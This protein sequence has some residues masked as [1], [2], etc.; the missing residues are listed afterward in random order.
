MTWRRT[1]RQQPI[2]Q[3]C[4]RHE[5]RLL[6]PGATLDRCLFAVIFHP[7]TRSLAVS[8]SPFLCLELI[9]VPQWSLFY[10]TAIVPELNPFFFF[11]TTWTTVQLWLSLTTVNTHVT[12]D[13]WRLYGTCGL[14]SMCMTIVWFE[15]HGDTVKPGFDVPLFRRGHLPEEDTCLCSHVGSSAVIH[16]VRCVQKAWTFIPL[17]RSQTMTLFFFFKSPEN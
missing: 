7:P 14:Q 6:R 2:A 13:G 11:L 5:S 12:N 3:L 17:T 15:P 9:P 16:R 8:A 4:L 1:P 10:P